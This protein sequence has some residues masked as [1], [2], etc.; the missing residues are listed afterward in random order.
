MRHD[1]IAVRKYFSCSSEFHGSLP[2]CFLISWIT[3]SVMVTDNMVLGCICFFFF[4]VLIT[5]LSPLCCWNL[6]PAK[7]AFNHKCYSWEEAGPDIY[8]S[9]SAVV[10]QGLFYTPWWKQ[11]LTVKSNSFKNPTL[12]EVLNTGSNKFSKCY[13]TSGRILSEAKP[14]LES[15]WC[16]GTM[17]CWEQG[18]YLELGSISWDGFSILSSSKENAKPCAA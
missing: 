1:F 4:W 15:H 7:D 10:S 2:V 16:N 18:T 12:C 17:S 11:T 5:S 9:V 14:I 3:A 13:S 8:L 6:N